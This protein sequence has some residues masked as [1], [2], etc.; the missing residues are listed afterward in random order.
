LSI[1]GLRSFA[2]RGLKR[3]S[4][5]QSVRHARAALTKTGS[6]VCRRNWERLSRTYKR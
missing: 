2:Y 6:S 5:C 3:C 4:K 1:A